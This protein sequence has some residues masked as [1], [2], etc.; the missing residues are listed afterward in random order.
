MN[1]VRWAL[2]GAGD[3]AQKRVGPALKAEPRSRLEIIV[4]VSPERAGKLADQLGGCV[5][6]DRLETALAN[7]A[8]D[9]VYLA[10]PIGMHAGQVKAALKSGKYVLCEKPL[11]LNYKEACC[12]TALD[13]GARAKAGVAYFRRFYPKYLQAQDM[14][15]AGAFGQV[16]LLRLAYHT[17]CEIKPDNPKFWRMLKAQS[18][19]GVLSD[20]GSHMFDVMIGLFGLPAAVFASVRTQTFS[21]EAE[22]SAA[23]VM[24][25]EHGPDVTA[26]FNWNSKTW[27][28]E[29]EIIGT[30]AKVRWH[31]YDS[32]RVT[33]TIGRDV[34]ELELPN[35]ANVHYP[36]I[37]DFVSAILE[38]RDPAV[39]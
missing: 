26:S 22:D 4:D 11:G 2:I 7:P 33:R 29:F 10:T 23:M 15:K 19:G 20:M 18:G 36:L 35:H 34:Q 32:A 5:V 25:Y 17:W 31:P 12:L 27:T 13:N 3:I 38:G 14:L 8:I 16:V 39:T 37:A 6:G 30:E 21:C 28:H 9:A 24:K 1:K